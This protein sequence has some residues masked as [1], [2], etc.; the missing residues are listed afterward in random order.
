MPQ[1][2]A[3]PVFR[4]TGQAQAVW[5]MGSLHERVLTASES[6]GAIGLSVVTQPPGTATPLHVHHKE[7]EAFYLLEG[8]MT[9]RAG[10]D[11]F[12][13]EAGDFIYL[14]V[15]IPHAFRITGASAARF[16][17]LAVPGAVLDLYQE[18]GR[19]ARE[20]RLPEA[21]PGP[22]E[23]AGWL[24]AAGRYGIEVLGPPLP[25]G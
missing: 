2:T 6:D 18:V 7:A 3:G 20:R 8:S 17:A 10:K 19:P 1:T 13:L 25:E 16:L 23:I 24:E 14:P 22:E 12:R 4:A 21:P 5:S 15:D 11:V 9:Y